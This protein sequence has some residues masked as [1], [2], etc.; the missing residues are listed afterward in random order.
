[1]PHRSPPPRSVVV[2]SAD[3]VRSTWTRL[4]PA[5]A[6]Y[7][8][9]CDARSPAPSHVSTIVNIVSPRPTAV[10]SPTNRSVV[11]SATPPSPRPPR[12]ASAGRQGSSAGDVEVVRRNIERQLES[13]GLPGSGTANRFHS[14]RDADPP[15]PQQVSVESIRRNPAERTV[16]ELRCRQ[17]AERRPTQRSQQRTRRR[18]R[19]VHTCA[20]GSADC[21]RARG[22]GSA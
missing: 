10:R 1:M 22:S 15:D 6:A 8:S 17:L 5:S 13:R 11:M 19:S 4:T 7:K 12:V 9:A 21:G 16:G 14:Q 3:C 18:P 2:Q 20:A